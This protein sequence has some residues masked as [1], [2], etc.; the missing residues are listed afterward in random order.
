M[1]IKEI[2]YKKFFLFEG[3][4]FEEI[5]SLMEFG[6]VKNGKFSTNQ[7]LH[8]SQCVDKIGILIKGKAAIKSGEN[9]VI[10]KKVAQYEA[11][12]AASLFDKP[13][14]L[15]TVYATS[16]GE[17][18][19]IDKDFVIHCLLNNNKASLNYITFLSKKITFLNTKINAYTAKS[20]ENKLYTYLLQL[21]RNG[22]ELNLTINLATLSKMIGV[23]RATLYRAFEKLENNGLITKIDKKIILNEV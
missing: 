14:Y 16:E 3:L 1:N 8:D 12:G 15:T 7:I 4:T 11:F 2:L 5:D 9:G 21:P 10:I 19:T 20:A 13:K 18:L 17:M 6:G 22:N 23:G